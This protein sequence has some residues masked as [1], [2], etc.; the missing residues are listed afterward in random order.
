MKLILLSTRIRLAVMSLLV[1][2][3]GSVNKTAAQICADPATI[4]YGLAGNGAIYPITVSSATVGT[5]V[6]NTTYT[7]NAPSK[8]NG[9]AY[10]STNGK[11]YYFKRNVGATPQEFVSYDP[12][13]AT[14]TILATSTCAAEV[15]TG[16][17]T[18][19][20]LYYYTIDV[21]ANMNCYN[22]VTN[23]WTFITSSFVDQFGSNVSTVIQNQS[24]GDI[25]FDGNQNLWMVTSSATNYGVYCISATLPK[26]P[27]ASITAFRRVN[28]TTATPS[29]NSIA[30]IAFNP[31]GQIFMATKNDN[32]LYRLENNLSL[33]FLGTFGIS[34]VGNDLTSCAF[35]LSVLPITWIHFS[36]ASNTK[37]EVD[38]AWQIGEKPFSGFH[39]QHST[40]GRTWNDISFVTIEATDIEG[41][42]YHF[43]DRNPVRGQNYY[44]IK[45]TN[46]TGKNSYS[47]VKVVAITS[48]ISTSLSIWPNP[49]AEYI[50]VSGE[51]TSVQRI[52]IYDLAGRLHVDKTFAGS[53][54][55]VNISSL[56]SGAYLVS[57][58]LADGRNEN[59]KLIKQ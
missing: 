42:T 18:A 4:I 9:L 56:K 8:A 53:Q 40:D 35:P 22:I 41:M 45:T 52:R 23:T 12:A 25:A 16:C 39:I 31:S 5:A 59:K 57:L 49:A 11:F 47:P 17:I 29:G 48:G 38:L 28:S 30:G 2:C 32:R 26:T 37:N 51:N 54:N 34:D 50:S 13:T 3:V 6:K 24:A 36:A 46:E 58:Q 15:H 44:R 14:V 27:V 21:N 19:D 33:T 20:G 1:L 7:G 43:T 10:N 55:T